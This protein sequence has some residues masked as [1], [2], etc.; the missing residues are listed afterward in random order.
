V[1]TTTGKA[2]DKK[3]KKV[4][5]GCPRCSSPINESQCMSHRAHNERNISSLMIYRSITPISS[6]NKNKDFKKIDDL[7]GLLPE[8]WLSHAHMP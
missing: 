6:F 8:Q 1:K 5:S 3:I 4:P 7:L 2:K